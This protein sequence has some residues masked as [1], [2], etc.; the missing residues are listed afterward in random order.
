MT[1]HSFEYIQNFVKESGDKLISKEYINNT[2]L[3]DIQCGPC[4]K[5]Y[6]L[7]Y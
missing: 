2:S 3:L 4:M 5:V 6:T 7:Y 1:K